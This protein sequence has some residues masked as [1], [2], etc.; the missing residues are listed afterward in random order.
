VFPYRQIPPIRPDQAITQLPDLG[1]TFPRV[2]QL[3]K[4]RA[5]RAGTSLSDCNTMRNFDLLII[6][7]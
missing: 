6:V 4:K 2:P 3:L 7:T 1:S 5:I